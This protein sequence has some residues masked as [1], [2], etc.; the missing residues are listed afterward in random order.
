MPPKKIAAKK[1]PTSIR[2]VTKKTTA[3][4]KT[5]TKSTGATGGKLKSGGFALFYLYKS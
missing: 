3:T 1:P 5:P 2:T 4:S